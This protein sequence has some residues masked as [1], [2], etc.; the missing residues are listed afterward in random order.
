[1]EH[2]LKC[3]CS[4]LK[5]IVSRQIGYYIFSDLCFRGYQSP[6]LA[7]VQRIVDSLICDKRIQ[8]DLNQVFSYKGLDWTLHKIICMLMRCFEW[9]CPLREGYLPVW[10]VSLIASFFRN[11]L[12]KLL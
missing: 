9:W 4:T 11:P 8:I 7:S 5:T 6:V 12:C 1:M 10:D 3:L 2:C